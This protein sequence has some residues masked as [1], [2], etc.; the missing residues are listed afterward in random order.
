MP[1]SRF[2]GSINS[3]KVDLVVDMGNPFLNR[4]VDGFLKIG[5]V[6]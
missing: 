2:A 5:T 3:P 4:T 1:R 6:S